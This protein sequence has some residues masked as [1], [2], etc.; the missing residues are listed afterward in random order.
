M[1][2]KNIIANILIIIGMT[3][4]YYIIDIFLRYTSY[5]SYN[6][7]SYS[8]LSPNIF[9]L[10]WIALFIGIFY[11]LP[12]K[13]KNI[14]YLTNLIFFNLIA[15][16]QYL[17][18][19]IL[20]RFYGINDLTLINEGKSYFKYAIEKSD[21]KIIFIMVL[22]ITIGIIIN[23]LSKKY[24]E[25][26]RDKI[27]Y[28][29]IISFT[30]IISIFLHISGYFQ[31]GKNVESDDYTDS[32]SPISNYKQFSDPNKNMQISGLYDNLFHS[33]YIYITQN[34][35]KNKEI[36]EQEIKE[37]QKKNNKN[38]SE[39]EY[40]GV[41]KNKDIIVILMESIDEFLVTENIMPTLYELKNKGLNFV[42]RYSPSF[43]GGQTIN[44]EFAINTGL[45]SPSK[46]NIYNYNNTYKTSLAN[47]FKKEGYIVESI[48]YNNGYYY[49]RST[50]HKNLGYDKHY[51]LK[52]MNN[53]D[54]KKYNYEYDSNLIK[55]TKIYDLIVKDNKY[56]TFITT[57]SA[58]LPYNNTNKKCLEKK[59][60]LTDSTE[61]LSCIYNL[62][63]DTDEMIRLLIE[64]LKKENKLDNTV[65]VLASDHYMYGYS[66]IFKI[67]KE[68]NPNLLQKTPLIIYNPNLNHEN[69]ENYV[70][71]AD[72]LPTLLNMFDIKYNPNN[73]IGEDIFSS[74]RENY[75]YFSN[76]TYYDGILND[77]PNKENKDIFKHI[78]EKIK[79]NNN[80][81]E[82]NYLKVK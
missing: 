18:Y 75:I 80:L 19:K 46:G 59:Y 35:S 42:N 6:F 70:D 55:N 33:I 17:H 54:N 68:N 13:K 23:K 57:Y 52:D 34:K 25:T 50:F 4:S 74:K 32:F 73:Y 39:N 65:L 69:I 10:S 56:L 8:K 81:I 60:K 43:G 44:S 22:S 28:I 9:T 79:Y 71:T 20:D 1:K 7:Y 49:N 62:A 61:E 16:T 24:H 58:H 82:S 63:H 26:Y 21:I 48:H 72:I 12:Q 30:L 31:L 3:I 11:L 15:Y 64:K 37:Y 66:E 40:T 47:M 67:R 77:N 53:I 51:A 27:Y 5:A 14:Y 78:E 2:N 45:Y 36:M 76:N 29:F 38:L 41:L